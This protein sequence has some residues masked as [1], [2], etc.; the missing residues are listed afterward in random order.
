MMHMILSL[1]FIL[2]L[3]GA[4]AVV[5]ASLWRERARIVSI[6]A[7]GGGDRDAPP[8]CHFRHPPTR[9]RLSR[10]VLTVRRDSP[11]RAAA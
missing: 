8:E 1:F 9:Q 4:C 3:G 2:C 5:M 11:L 6:L 10:P 7:S